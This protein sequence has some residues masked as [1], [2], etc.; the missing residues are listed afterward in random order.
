MKKILLI[1]I[2]IVSNVFSETSLYEVGKEMRENF[3]S[4]SS[5]K[6]QTMGYDGGH[7]YKEAMKASHGAGKTTG[8]ATKEIAIYFF[9]KIFD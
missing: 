8:K 9:Q 2:L 5:K 4:E 7:M 6:A 3:L 1:L